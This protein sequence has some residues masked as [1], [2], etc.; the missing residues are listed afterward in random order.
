VTNPLTGVR[1]PA[2]TQIP[3]TD[4]QPFA[5][6]VLQSLPAPTSLSSS[7]NYQVSQAFKNSMISTMRNSITNLLRN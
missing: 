6:Q 1:Y 3:A 7:N 5:R 2:G 4:I